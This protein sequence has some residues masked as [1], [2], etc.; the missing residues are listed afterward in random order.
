MSR[1][2]LDAIAA[3]ALLPRTRPEEENPGTL[4]LP[5][6]GLGGSW[7]E[8]AATPEETLSA[9]GEAWLETEASAV[10]ATA[11]AAAADAAAA[12]PPEKEADGDG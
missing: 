11:S 5:L 2:N 10:M 4:S 1:P 7:A 3:I 6:L 12:P 8:A 9:V